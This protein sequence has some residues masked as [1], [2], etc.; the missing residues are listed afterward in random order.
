MVEVAL[1]RKDGGLMAL[2]REE[3]AE[4]KLLRRRRGARVG[5]TDWVG[6]E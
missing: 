2:L 5:L 3:V 4:E 1:W 6:D